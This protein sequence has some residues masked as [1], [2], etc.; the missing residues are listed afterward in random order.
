MTESNHNT[1]HAALAGEFLPGP[2][3]LIGPPGA[4]KGTQAKILVTQFGVPQISTG[5]LLRDHRTR[6]TEL[7]KL[8]ESLVREGKLVPDDLVNEMVASRLSEPDA[9]QG[10]ILDG[11]PRT[12]G[13]A[14]WLDAYTAEQSELPPLVAVQIRVDEDQLLRRITGRRSCPQC[15]CIYN[16]YSNPP[17]I[18]NRCNDDGAALLQRDDDTEESFHKRMREYEAKTLPVVPHYQNSGRFRSV[19]GDLS[20]EAVA[21]EIV[22]ALQELRAEFPAVAGSVK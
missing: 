20:V 7:G 17:K 16:I 12:L 14:Q 8:F 11:F 4:G 15:G 13:Q 1:N 2:V 18:E 3:L 10:Y 19:N 9:A 6:Q 5:D 21:A 22:A